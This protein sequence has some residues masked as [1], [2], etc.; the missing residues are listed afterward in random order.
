MYLSTIH[1]VKV[2]I[3]FIHI[4]E[5]V[6]DALGV[7]W[8]TGSGYVMRRDALDS[9]GNFPLGSLAEDV[10]TSSM[11]LGA[12]WNTVFV[13]EP[14]QFGTVPDS[15]SGRLKQRTR[16]T[17]GTV[18]TSLK[19]KFCLYGPLVKHMSIMQK[20]S[21]FVYT[22]SSLCTIFLVLSLFTVLIVLYEGGTMVPYAST[23]QLVLLIRLNFTTMICNRINEW[24]TYL[25]SGY[26]VGQR[27]ARGM[28]W[29]AP[30][31]H[32][33]SHAC[34]CYIGDSILSTAE[35]ARWQN[36]SL[37]ILG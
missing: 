2:S 24:V 7:A 25:P 34:S 19:L 30:C 20:A 27:D 17:I 36:R 9:I 32:N 31:K 11:L 22:V 16:W 14:L 26:F 5:P 4:S 1:S 8:C 37:Y 13:H 12:G 6:K 3:P 23:D 29:M 33:F 28:L 35:M 15:L 18:Q 21:G 10:C